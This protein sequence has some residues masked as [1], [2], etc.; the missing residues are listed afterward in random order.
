MALSVTGYRLYRLDDWGLTPGMATT[1]RLAL[2]PSPS[3]SPVQWL[4]GPLSQ[5]VKYPE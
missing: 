3:Q 2:G 5:R 4:L 1:L